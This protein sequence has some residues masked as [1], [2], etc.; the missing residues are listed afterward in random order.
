MIPYSGDHR[1]VTNDF[2]LDVP[3]GEYIA[4]KHVTGGVVL[5]RQGAA[6]V[7]RGAFTS[8][9]IRLGAAATELILTWNCPAPMNTL[10]SVDF[11]VRAAGGEWSC[12]FQMGD[13]KSE[14]KQDRKSFDFIYG[15]LKT[16]H[17]FAAGVFDE[18]QYRVVLRTA[19][20]SQSP[21]LRRVTLC[22]SDTRDKKEVEPELFSGA[23]MDLP[24]PWLS[25]FDPDTVKDRVMME[26]GVCAATS[27]TMVL[28]HHGMPANV[29]D[30]GRRAYDPSAD[31]YGNWAF[32]AAAA[33]E[34]GPAAWVQRFS[35]WRQVESFIT[36]GIPVIIS[37]AYPKGTFSAEPDKET[38]G[39]LIVVR[40]FTA[41][42]DAIVNDP[43]T[44]DE[45]RG[46][47]YVYPRLEL[48]RAF[49]GHGGVGIII[50]R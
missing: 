39:H 45:K 31:I 6:S 26:A 3:R 7:E 10:A 19:D 32:L 21:L 41:T 4:L 33:A 38:K 18:V 43:G 17:F 42:G 37:I 34:Y 22:L 20:Y 28:K 50:K 27:V 1:I 15:E 46:R 23:A 2:S 48:G 11:R 13:W 24:A 35:D 44:A 14:K 47:G 30:V 40:G 36:L 25:Q 29:R 12:W 8:E 9:I 16:D 5:D 49:F